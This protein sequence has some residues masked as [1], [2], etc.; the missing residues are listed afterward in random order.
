MFLVR[1]SLLLTTTAFIFL[2]LSFFL[3]LFFA[4]FGDSYV[5]YLLCGSKARKEEQRSY[6]KLQC[7]LYVVVMQGTVAVITEYRKPEFMTVAGHT[8]VPAAAKTFLFFFSIH[9]K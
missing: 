1:C 4:R 2:F 5:F 8:Q 6:A 7:L 3:S 9:R